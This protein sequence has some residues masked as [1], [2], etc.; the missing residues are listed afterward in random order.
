M[1]VVIEVVGVVAV[2][3]GLAYWQIPAVRQLF[4][5]NR[6]KVIAASSTPLER[7]TDNVNQ[8]IAKLPAQRALVAQQMTAAQRAQTNAQNKR[9][10]VE[11][12]FKQVNVAIG[13]NAT[14]ATITTLKQR[15]LTAKGAVVDLDK[16]SEE[17]HKSA[18][19]AQA[20]LEDLLT[21]IQ[22]SKAGAEKLKSDANLTAILQQ[23]TQ[24]RTQVN[25][26]KSGLGANAADVQEVQDALSNARN[27]NELSKGSAADRE[28]ADIAKKTQA[29]AADDAFAAELAAR[30]G[31]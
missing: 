16:V 12:L 18:D 23:S 19:D 21:L 4:R 8:A 30:A 24:F 1:S 13:A 25:D 22:Q 17:A 31:K 28:M 3:G 14:A 15:W 27:A 20:E 9:D 11:D 29:S 26:L 7:I 6:D 5:I 2:V 10:E